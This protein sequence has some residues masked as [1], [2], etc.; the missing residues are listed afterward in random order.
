MRKK[1]ALIQDGFDV[2][3]TM[4]F[5]V[6]ILSDMENNGILKETEQHVTAPAA[7]CTGAVK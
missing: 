1:K 2:F 4:F 6:F 5:S 7:E 3:L